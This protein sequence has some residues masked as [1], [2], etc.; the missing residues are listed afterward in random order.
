MN[1]RATERERML[2]GAY[3]V[4][5]EVREQVTSEDFHTKRY[6]LAVKDVE[7]FEASE[8]KKEGM[9][10]LLYLMETLGLPNGAKFIDGLVEST[11]QYSRA[12]RLQMEC[13]KSCWA[14]KNE[15]VEAVKEK[16]SQI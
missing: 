12:K 4:S 8:I 10:Y 1:N 14:T 2:F 13:M 11:K 7:K 3:M 9:I 16:V 6:R 15:D 5:P